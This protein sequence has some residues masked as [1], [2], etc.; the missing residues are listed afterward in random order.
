[1]G[2]KLRVAC[3]GHQIY[4]ENHFCEKSD[5]RFKVGWF[6]FDHFSTRFYAPAAAFRPDIT[7]VYRPELHKPENLATLPGLKIGFSTE[8]LPKLRQSETIRSEETDRRLAL[9]NDLP[10]PAYDA[11]FHYDGASQ[12]FCKANGY[13]FTGFRTLPVNTDYFYG[14]PDLRKLWDVTFVGKATSRRMR[15]LDRLKIRNRRFLWVE[16]GVSGKQ[17]GDIFR[18]SKCVLNIHADNLIALEPRVYLAACCRVP[19]LSDDLSSN[20]FPFAQYVQT[21]SLE[22]LT[23]ELIDDAINKVERLNASSAEDF[24]ERELVRTS[25]A[26]F[27]LDAVPRLT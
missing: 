13:C 23:Y 7:L 17:L 24:W 20:E 3:I 10:F 27:I 1:L 12:T 21:T 5:P 6:D 4:F 15:I 9:L 22:T 19:V 16:H 18:R 26:S 2:A 25:V 14:R 11:V 8:P